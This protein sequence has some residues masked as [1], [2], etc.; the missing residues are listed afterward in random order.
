MKQFVK[1]K[2]CDKQQADTIHNCK[3]HQTESLTS[4]NDIMHSFD[5]E[6]DVPHADDSSDDIVWDYIYDNLWKCKLLNVL[7]HIW[8][9]HLN[10]EIKCKILLKLNNMHMLVYS[11]IKHTY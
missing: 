3:K 4:Y 10:F 1:T 11:H 2:K 5:D 7:S 6:C 9:L 8:K